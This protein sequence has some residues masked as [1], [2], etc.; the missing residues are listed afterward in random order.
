MV[1][2]AV[3][4]HGSLIAMI[5]ANRGTQGQGRTLIPYEIPELSGF[6]AWLAEIDDPVLYDRGDYATYVPRWTAR[7]GADRLLWASDY[8]RLR[9]ADARGERD[10][11]LPQGFTPTR[12]TVRIGTICTP[13][14]SASA[15]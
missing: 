14:P 2:E 4:A 15:R 12:V 6:E 5:D 3:A 11:V 8:T 9:M 7:F 13:R 1:A 10:I